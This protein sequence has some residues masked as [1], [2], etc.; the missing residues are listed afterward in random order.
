MKKLNFIFIMTILSILLLANFSIAFNKPLSIPIVKGWNLVPQ[1]ILSHDPINENI[2]IESTSEITISDFRAGYIYDVFQ[3]KHILAIKNG[4][5][6]EGWNEELSVARQDFGTLSLFYTS[7][8]FYSD[9]EGILQLSA[10]ESE[11][12]ISKYE[13]FQ[14]WKS[15]S[16]AGC[17]LQRRPCL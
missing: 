8:W 17:L 9:K 16:Y 2:I 7:T 4:E 11:E 15:A 6:R 1:F 3:K 14:G 13:I 12:E 10:F 5:F